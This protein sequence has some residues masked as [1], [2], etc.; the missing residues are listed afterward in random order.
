MWHKI[1]FFLSGEFFIHSFIGLFIV[2]YEHSGNKHVSVPAPPQKIT[3]AK[4]K[5]KKNE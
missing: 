1:N 3:K 2:Q 4:K 5:K